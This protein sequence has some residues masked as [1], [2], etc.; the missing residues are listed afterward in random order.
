MSDL[1]SQPGG[2]E[3]MWI[4]AART[5]D[6]N[7]A[8]W[9]TNVAP[10]SDV[11]KLEPALHRRILRQLVPMEHIAM[12]WSLNAAAEKTGWPRPSAPERALL[13]AQGKPI[14]AAVDCF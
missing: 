4:V 1:L 9:I 13:G 2:S 8:L 10:E 12:A 11:R 3:Y 7:V 6:D 5:H 14:Q